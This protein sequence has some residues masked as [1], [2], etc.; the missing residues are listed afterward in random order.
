MRK[1]TISAFLIALSFSAN[2]QQ[3]IKFGAKAGVN[4]ATLSNVSKAKMLTG[5]YVGAVAEIKLTAKFSIQ[6]ELVYSSQGAK[7][8]YSE[9]IIGIT[10]EHS[11]HDKLDYINIPV[12]A[13]YYIT[14]RFS[15]ELGP[16]FGFLI[17]AESKDE[18]IVNDVKTTDTR[19]FKNEVN[20]FDFGI[21]A[22]LAYDLSNGIF[23]NGRYNLG[24][25]NV[26]KSD[27]YYKDA[28][29]GVIQVGVGYKF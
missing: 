8:T 13:K 10:T 11:N 1:I 2:A 24:L 3:E 16:Q 14:D 23:L 19:D 25:T 12:L 20:S 7:N 6:P 28:K 21:G 27:E 4:F 15:F 18:I 29:N 9:T 17:K 26:G 22:G 5:F